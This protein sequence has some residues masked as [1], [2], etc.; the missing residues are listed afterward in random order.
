MNH[1]KQWSHR[2]GRAVDTSQCLPL[3]GRSYSFPGP[4]HIHVYFF[5]SFLVFTCN[6]LITEL[7]VFSRGLGH[8]IIT[9][10]ESICPQSHA[11]RQRLPQCFKCINVYF[12][13][14]KMLMKL[15][16]IK[17]NERGKKGKA[18]WPQSW[19][20]PVLRSAGELG[21]FCPN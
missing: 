17:V 20:S 7:L 12:F 16:H 11:A 1:Q 14:P 3:L 5:L 21:Q 15:Q 4:I 2:M 13:S 8:V 10:N 6:S 19:G 18:M 9:Y